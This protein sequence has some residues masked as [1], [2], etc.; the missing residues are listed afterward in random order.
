[1]SPGGEVAATL[2]GT[3]GGE[4]ALL[5][6]PTAS[7]DIVPASGVGM[8][9]VWDSAAAEFAA[10]DVVAG[11]TLF[12]GVTGQETQL[13]WPY[14]PAA[15]G[16]FQAWQLIAPVAGGVAEDS[17]P[18]GV[19]F[20]VEGLADVGAIGVVVAP[21]SPPDATC[22]VLA[23]PTAAGPWEVVGSEPCHIDGN[24]LPLA[25]E[26]PAGDTWFAARAVV[27][28]WQSPPTPATEWSVPTAAGSGG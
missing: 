9:V 8:G 13:T 19:A 2:P 27:N 3:D 25:V 5:S 11:G 26:V 21:A 28:A 14:F 4:V 22:E 20:V 6:S 17:R 24:Y 7:P 15:G 16:P 1:V 23:G 10:S 12:V 18:G